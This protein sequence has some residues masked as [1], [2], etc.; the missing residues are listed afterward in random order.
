MEVWPETAELILEFV[1]NDYLI[2]QSE[3]KGTNETERTP[4]SSSRVGDVVLMK[5]N[6]PCG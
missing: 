2:T 1:G 6:L 4:W 5:E 3:G